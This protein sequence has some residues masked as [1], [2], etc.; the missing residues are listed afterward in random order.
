MKKIPKGPASTTRKNPAGLTNRQVDV[1]RLLADG[2]TNAEIAEDL[3]VST[4]TVDHH[5]SAVLMKL[6][7]SSRRDAASMIDE[8]G[9]GED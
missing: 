2:L 5:V 7:V 4:R 6:G 9:L 1:L 3:F 8:L